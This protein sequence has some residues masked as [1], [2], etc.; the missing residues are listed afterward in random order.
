VVPYN[1]EEE[2]KKDNLCHSIS[3]VTNKD[4]KTISGNKQLKE[5]S[6]M[7][8]YGYGYINIFIYIYVFIY[9]SY[10]KTSNLKP[11]CNYM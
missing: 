8:K 10:Q 5:H 9:I 6:D 4:L 7:M 2:K 11:S 1:K 3:S